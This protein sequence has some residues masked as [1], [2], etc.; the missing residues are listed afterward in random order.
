ME[1][2]EGHRESTPEENPRSKP[3]DELEELTGE[4]E[5]GKG[6]LLLCPVRETKRTE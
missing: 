2:N 6:L 4:E 5:T 1:T 3:A